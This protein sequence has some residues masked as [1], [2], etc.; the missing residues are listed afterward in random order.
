MET[1]AENL[2]KQRSSVKASITRI[3]N[4]V[5][6]LM[7]P[8]ELE[9]RLGLLEAYFKQILSIQ[10]TIENLN[11]DDA[12]RPSVEEL[13]ITTKAKIIDLMGDN[14]KRSGDSSFCVSTP[15]VSK[16][17]LPTLHLPKFEGKYS[18]YKNFMGT[19]KQLVHSDGTLSDIERFN[20]LLHC[21][22]GPALDTV[23]AFEITS[24]N[25]NKAIKRLDERYNNKTLI[26]LEHISNIHNLASM[27]H[28]SA[29]Q[30]RALVDNASAIY[31]SLKSLGS[32]DDISNAM[33]IHIV[34]S[35]VDAESSMKWKE[36]IDFSSL[37]NWDNFAAVLER[38]CQYLESIESKS[39]SIQSSPSKQ[40]EKRFI[41]NRP[42][43]RQLFFT[44]NQPKHCNFCK[45]SDH[46]S[47]LCAQFKAL[48][49]TSRFDTVKKL[50]LCI[51]CF[52]SGHTVSNCSSKHQCKLCHQSHHTL[53]HRESTRADTS[54][55][56]LGAVNAHIDSASN[57]VILAT[58]LVLIR[59]RNGYFQVGRA[60]LDSCSQ[61]NLISERFASLLNLHRENTSV[62][63]SGV[64][65][66]ISKIKHVTDSTIRSRFNN[67]ELNIQFLITN[68]ISG[69]LPAENL[70]ISEWNLPKIEFA[71]EFFHR[72]QP[73]DMLI[74][75]EHF[76]N[77][78]S[79]GQQSLGSNLPTLQESKLGW[80]V[81]GRYS[82]S[83]QSSAC[84]SMI[85][86][87]NDLNLHKQMQFLWKLEDV[88]QSLSKWSKDQQACEHH[89]VANVKTLSSG[90]IEVKLPFKTHPSELGSSY[91]S[92]LKRFFMLEKRLD[93]NDELKSQYVAFM[94]DYERLGHM[95][96]VSKPALE[97]PHYFIPHHCVLRPTSSS[98]KLRVVFDASAK[99]TTQKSLNDLLFVGPTI[100]DDLL[101][102]VLRFRMFKY[103]L[104]GDVVK[105]YRM[106]SVH[107]SD[108]QFQQILW[109][110][111]ETQP[112]KVYQLNTITYGMAASPFLAIRSLHFL[113]DTYDT[114]YKIGAS[115][116]KNHFYV[117][118]MLTGSNSVEELQQIHKEVSKILANG[119]LELAK[120]Q[121][122]CKSLHFEAANPKLLNLDESQLHSAL[123]ISWD[124]NKDIFCFAFKPK[125]TFSFL[126]KRTILS[127]TASIFDPM[128]LICPIIIIP[129][130]LLQN[131]W[132][133]KFDWDTEVPND[134]K[135]SFNKCLEDLGNLQ[136]L[137]VPRYVLDGTQKIFLHGFSDASIRAYGC[138]FYVT[139]TNEYNISSS[140][141][142]AAKCRVAPTKKRTLPQLEL[143][144]A[145]LLTLLYQK[146]APLFITINPRVFLWTDSSVVLRW[147]QLHSSTL[148][149]FVGNR[150]SEMQEITHNCNWK[151]V[152]TA[153]NPADLISRG[154]S[155]EVL[156]ESLWFQGP[157]FLV[158]DESKWPNSLAN[159]DSAEVQSAVRKSVF[160]CD[161]KDNRI[162]E[163]CNHTS[164]YLLTLRTVV[165]LLRMIPVNRC[166]S[167]Q[168]ATLQRKAFLC[169]A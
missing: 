117:D 4:M 150:I 73:I 123:G 105:M 124:S 131:L 68:R 107:K 5:T 106:F 132:L 10:S 118:D 54:D 2:E 90:R 122:N 29:P 32:S 112:I 101:I 49:V 71:D 127:L 8:S 62:E 94:E 148:T 80:I 138:C 162:I 27:K 145:H 139:V 165:I 46:W 144:G 17:K 143:C 85:T 33:L 23:R 137:S 98:T 16:S 121:S 158:Q 113:S 26:F 65:A 11:P 39:S 70:N 126:T 78:L 110:A 116:L 159:Y 15:L 83:Q 60:L 84:R 147:L 36:C 66:S 20:H 128:G 35:K 149:T 72:Q 130:V 55:Q 154:C 119:G 41:S 42:Q 67:F 88:K 103:A 141:L 93:Q 31:S 43:Q 19:F 3:K 12:G 56:S 91:N 37:P 74:G 155:L 111:S 44:Q 166:K 86:T 45:S 25:Y 76:F 9:C 129:R 142:F 125:Q 28:S 115:V 136:K 79:G 135:Q 21:L 75:T 69:Y 100:Q 6:D 7:T 114:E 52:S 99:T 40:V 34:L 51:N 1:K 48:D 169:I 140:T 168:T 63:I 167:I 53:L 160:K 81:T 58:A 97:F 146:I 156:R 157:S 57:G 13:C 163:L 14:Y 50:G 92:A 30:L 24:E 152:P 133:Q 134:V 89:F 96:I 18:T 109:R 108:R 161:L 59:D 153:M 77:I 120:I 151:H 22:S 164:S 82:T 87:A 38:R 95:S 47:S 61:V 104:T 64:G 102:Q